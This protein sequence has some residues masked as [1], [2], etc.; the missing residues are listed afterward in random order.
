MRTHSEPG[1]GGYSRDRETFFRWMVAGLGGML[2]ASGIAII[3]HEILLGQISVKIDLLME[4]F[5]VV[6]GKIP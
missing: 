3:R 5:G 6:G 2:L 1:S 4:H